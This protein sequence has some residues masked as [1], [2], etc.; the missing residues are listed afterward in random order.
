MSGANVGAAVAFDGTD[1]GGAAPYTHY[2]EDI[3]TAFTFRSVPILFAS[4]TGRVLLPIPPRS[5]MMN[6][7][8][9]WKAVY[10]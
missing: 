4:Q 7:M 5:S 2:G 1:C 8:V 10:A 6:A 9:R 3:R